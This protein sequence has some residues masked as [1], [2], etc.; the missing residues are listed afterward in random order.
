MGRT[1]G[2]GANFGA[3]SRTVK[4][5]LIASDGLV[6]VCWRPVLPMDILITHTNLTR[7][8][9]AETYLLSL[10]HG[11]CE[12][13][14]RVHLVLAKRDP[15]LMLPAGCTVETV[16]AGWV[17]Q[18]LRPWF[19]DGL[20]RKRIA[21]RRG[22]SSVSLARNSGH[23]V[24]IN[25]GTHRGFLRAMQRRPSWGDRL[26]I[27]VERQAYE[28]ARG[29]V[30]HSRL[31]AE[32]LRN[33]YNIPESKITVIYPPVDR[34]RFRFGLRERRSE[35]RARWKLPVDKKLILF[36]STGHER[37]GLP[38]VVEAMRRL[39]TERYALVVAGRAA[40]KMADGIE[41]VSLGFVDA[42]DQVYAACDLTVLPSHYEPFGLV[43]VESALCGTPVI[44]GEKA[45]AAELLSPPIGSLL[46]ERTPEALAH[47]IAMRCEQATI[48]ANTQ[49]AVPA[50]VEHVAAFRRV[51]VDAQR[52]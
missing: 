34:E 31:V 4:P 7:G 44:F 37:K 18:K 26:Q 35:F 48:G 22:W 30:A 42:M 32:E 41:V 43:Y 50:V 47:L 3:G 9:G 16:Q 13:G 38:L 5:F 8:G 28:T 20:F 12:A 14:D 27:A 17:P 24:A 25:G 29:I 6:A 36:P 10:V 33:D 23:D 46:L 49:I 15:T 39:P 11:F 52:K 21:G 2:D 45:G 40:P 1:G 19:L 51:L